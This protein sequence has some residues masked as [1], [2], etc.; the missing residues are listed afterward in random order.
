MR[1]CAKINKNACH[2]AVGLV[3]EVIQTKS[4]NHM[5]KTTFCVAALAA[6]LLLWS[7]STA[8]ANVYATN[9]KLNGNQTSTVSVSQGMPITI[10]YVLN[11]PA[12]AGVTIKIMSGETVVRTIAIASGAGTLKGSN[13]VVWDGKDGQ[14]ANIAM[15]N[16]SVTVTA[17]ATGYADWT[18]ISN[19]S[20]PGNSLV[21]PLGIAVNKNVASP[22]YGRIIVGNVFKGPGFD[23]NGWGQVPGLYKYNADGSLSEDGAGSFATAGYN[24]VDPGYYDGVD[25]PLNMKVKEDDRVYW[26]NWVG[27]SEIV[28]A[29][30]LL[31]THQ[32][33][34]PEGF[35]SGNPYYPGYNWKAFEVTD[36][37][38]DHPR[39]YLCDAAFPSAGV[40]YWPMTNGAVDMDDPYATMGYQAIQTGG[41]LSLRCDGIAIDAKTN[42][43]VVQTR[44]NVSDASMRAA[45]WTNWDGQ[46]ILFSDAAW[47]VGGGDPTFRYAYNLALDSEQNPRYIAYSMYAIEANW[48]AGIRILNVED[49]SVVV[50]N[51]TPSTTYHGV[52]W[53]NVGNLYAGSRSAAKWRVFSPPGA[54]EATTPALATIEITAGVTPPMISAISITGGNAV[55]RF[56]GAA[57]DTAG[58]FTVES[59]ASLPGAFTAATGANVTQVSPGVFEATVPS[60]GP[61]GFYRIRK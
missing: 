27:K 53:D 26:N 14:G 57:E 52:V 18:Q 50:T 51:L 2:L 44:A 36:I 54:N 5:K 31:T 4:L 12:T 13:S 33:V 30:M 61:A 17:A 25:N 20:D 43:Y 60:S 10:G 9:I 8:R 11:E 40:W 55:I 35:Y 45:C 21:R 28:A 49:G 41:S 42:V 39:L 23:T 46:T 34:M 24:F 48:V 38:T 6:G 58:Q 22:Y 37:L 1:T 3:E 47:V 7:S 19:D 16:Y 59:T 29:D 56:T 15:G 32:V